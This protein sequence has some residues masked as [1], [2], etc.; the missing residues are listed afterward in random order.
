MRDNPLTFT[1]KKDTIFNFILFKIARDLC[2]FNLL[3]NINYK[4]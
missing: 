4:K 3:I 2:N 1:E